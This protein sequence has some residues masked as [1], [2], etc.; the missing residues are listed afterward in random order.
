MLLRNWWSQRLPIWCTG[1]LCKSQP[2]DDK[3][4]LIGAVQVM[5]PIKKFWGSNHITETAEPKVVT[6]RTQVGYI[7]SSNR[8]IY[9]QQKWRGYGHVT[10]LKILP[11]SVMQ[12]VARVCQRQLSYLLHLAYFWVFHIFVA[13]NHTH[14]KI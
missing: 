2:T 12:G 10:L 13:G 11:F 6:F 14:F 9:H 5:W 8:V 4:S 7:N 3:P 1:W